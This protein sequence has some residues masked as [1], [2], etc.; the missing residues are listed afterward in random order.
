MKPYAPLD[1]SR[2]HPYPIAERENLVDIAKFGRPVEP[3]ASASE[4][5][6]SLPA[7]LGA[8]SLRELAAAIARSRR[9]ERP[10]V[11]AMGAHVVKVG[12]GPLVIDLIERGIVTAVAV[13]GA[14]AI[15]DYEIALLGATSED[16]GDTIRDGSFG[17]ARETGEAYARAAKRGL[18]TG[19]GLGR[20]L[21]EEILG[22]PGTGAKPLPN[23]KL[24]VVAACAKKGIPCCV[25]VAMGTDTVHMHPGASGADLGGASHLDFR[26]LG[27]VACDL[28]GGVWANV[29][30]AVVL[31]EVFL[32]LVSIA[33]NLGNKLDDV[34]SAN[35]D[36][37]AHYRTS[38]NVLARPVRRGIS[39]LGHHEILIP[40]LRL[41]ILDALGKAT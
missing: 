5:L 11:F 16:V 24:S 3:G 40:L 23:A 31:P 32:K 25:H 35:L 37:I 38:A 33:R 6:S 26:L 29:G 4:F 13:N 41:A 15:H 27:A 28:E 30:S 20:A 12:C 8:E 1:L 36:M 22:D 10:V 14:F 19:K 21:G 9:A 2:T 39:I 17:F 18:E 7:F 34:T